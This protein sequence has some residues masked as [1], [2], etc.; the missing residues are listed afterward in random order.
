MFTVDAFR[1]AREE[2]K[3][4]LLWNPPQGDIYRGMS[5]STEDFLKLMHGGKLEPRAEVVSWTTNRGTAAEYSRGMAAKLLTFSVIFVQPVSNTE[6]LMDLRGDVQRQVDGG[7]YRNYE[8]VIPDA[9]LTRSMIANVYITAQQPPRIKKQA[10]AALNSLYE[11]GLLVDKPDEGFM[12][13][14]LD[15]TKTRL[16]EGA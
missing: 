6:I 10:F 11:E 3:D 7:A 9:P 15:K 13:Y 12:T 5:L 4:W 1:K 16:Q 14:I 8:V 2:F